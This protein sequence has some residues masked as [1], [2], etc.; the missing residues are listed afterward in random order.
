VKRAIDSKPRFRSEAKRIAYDHLEKL[1]RDAQRKLNS[2]RHEIHR[3]ARE[4][5]QLKN[6]VVALAQLMWEMRK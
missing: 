2:N 4:Q 1:H 5:R 6:D 3:L